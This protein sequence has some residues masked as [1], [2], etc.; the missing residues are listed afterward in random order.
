MRVGCDLDNVIIAIIESARRLMAADLGVPLDQIE[1]TN[2][3]WDPFTHADPAIAD[4][5]KPSFEFWNREDLLMGCEAL[6]GAHDAAWRLYDAGLLA[7]YITRRPPAV[8]HLTNAWLMINRFPP[9]PAEHVGATAGETY[10]ETCKSTI[11]S[12]YDVTHMIDD[13]AGEADMLA[14]AGIEVVLVDAPIGHAA[15]QEFMASHPHIRFAPNV[16]SV[17]DLLL[18]DHQGM[19]R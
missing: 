19:N 13:H 3:Y 17:A 12:R 1:E 7:C 9:V 4:K 10:F 16:G 5:L 14:K 15:R 18:A 6:P 8:S 2:I 11:C